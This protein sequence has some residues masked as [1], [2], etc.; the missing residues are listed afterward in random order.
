MVSPERNKYPRTP[1]VPASPGATSDDKLLGARQFGGWL[2]RDVVVTEKMDGENTTIY[3]D[4]FLHARSVDGKSHP[5]RSWVKALAASNVAGKLPEGFRI[6]GENLF[7]RHSI[8]YDSL[9]SFFLV[10]SIWDDNQCLDW[11][12]TGEWCGKLGLEHVPVLYEG[13]LGSGLVPSLAAK[14][15]FGKQEGFVIRSAG[16]FDL[17]DFGDN[18][19]KYV[20]KG[21]VQTAEHWSR[22]EI[23]PN[24]LRAVGGLTAGKPGARANEMRAL[25]GMG[26]R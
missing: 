9:S 4:G 3:W 18:V 12:T 20:R 21:H 23:V 17:S 7:A 5:S 16:S 6:C 26:G 22:G 10:F 19:A 24:R 25:K 8:E 1:H 13:K 14:M 2:G 15:N 11:R